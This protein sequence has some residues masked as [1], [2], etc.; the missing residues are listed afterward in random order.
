M[1]YPKIVILIINQGASMYSLNSLS[2]LMDSQVQTSILG[3]NT[4]PDKPHS[5][6]ILQLQ[7]LVQ[8]HATHS[9]CGKNRN[10][11][12]HLQIVLFM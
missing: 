10:Y 1:K 5:I 12:L 3:K 9:C 2:L 7:M 4:Q 11:Q 8:L 6:T